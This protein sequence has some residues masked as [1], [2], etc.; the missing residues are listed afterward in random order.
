MKFSMLTIAGTIASANAAI[1]GDATKVLKKMALMQK[2][3]DAANKKAFGTIRRLEENQN[4]NYNGG[5]VTA[6]TIIQPYM[7][8]TAN[9]YGY[10]ADG[11][12]GEENNNGGNYYSSSS[13][14]PTMSYLS[15]A[16]ASDANNNGYEYLY[17]DNDEYM[18]T[19]PNY[20]RAI[21]TAWAEERAQLCDDCESMENFW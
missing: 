4:Y 17:G 8:V 3:A 5:E 1:R 11:G 12:D 2:I 9:V 18:T 10:N 6:E 14:K 13:G 21:G 16:A 19:L 7:C 15:F 20:L